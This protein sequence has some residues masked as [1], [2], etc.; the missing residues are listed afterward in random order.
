[1]ADNQV[2]EIQEEVHTGHRAIPVKIVNKVIKSIC[3]IIIQKENGSKYY[4]TGFFL[5]I[6]NLLKCLITNYHVLNPSSI[7]F[8]IEIEIW[9]QKKVKLN[10]KNLFTKFFKQPKDIT[11][12]EIKD[13]DDICKDIEFLDYDYNYE[14]KGYKIYKDVDIF[15]IYHPLGDD[16]ECASG[17]IID[18]NDFEFQH[19]IPTEKGA[20]GCPI[21]LLNNN[22]NL[23]QVIG[24]HKNGNYMRGINGGTF[25][26]EI[27][28]EIKNSF[29]KKENI[30]EEIKENKDEDSNE[31]KIENF[32]IENYIIAE[33]KIN[34]YNINK[35][36]KIFNS[37]H[38]NLKKGKSNLAQKIEEDSKKYEIKI[39]PLK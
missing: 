3:K 23:I 20:S 27:I 17:K 5:R 39:N 8:Q 29:I 16:A 10:T 34:K 12:I 37:N 9:N 28:K 26:G 1:M 7:D 14:Q 30:N 19:K 15:S 35:N 36:V 11:V 33:I 21:I 13:L 24:I 4:G 2:N 6:T 31:N 32:E 18:I 25:I 38:K 22:Y